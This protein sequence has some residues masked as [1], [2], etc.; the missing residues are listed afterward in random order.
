MYKVTTK[1]GVAIETDKDMEMADLILFFI[2]H[3]LRWKKSDAE[4]VNC[5]NKIVNSIGLD[6]TITRE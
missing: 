5:L 3:E 4:V 1:F 2:R 6:L